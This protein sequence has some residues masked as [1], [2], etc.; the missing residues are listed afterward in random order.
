MNGNRSAIGFQRKTSESGMILTA[1][2]EERYASPR[3]MAIPLRLDENIKKRAIRTLPERK[4]FLRNLGDGLAAPLELV[5]ILT[6]AYLVTLLLPTELRYKMGVKP[7]TLSALPG[8]LLHPFLHFGARHLFFNAMALMIFGWLISLRSARTLMAVTAA[9]WLL[10]GALLWL[11]GRPGTVVGGA[12]GIVYGYLGFLLLRGIFD[13][14][15]VSM[16]LSLVTLYFFH[17]ALAGLLPT[18]T[19]VSWEGHLCGFAAGV[20]CAYLTKS[21]PRRGAGIRG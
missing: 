4:S 2:S 11:M 13:K 8:I 6:A 20:F 1:V 14:R 15:F 19:Q 5:A 21:S 3:N 7:R 16:G 18:D 10:G 17:G 12:S 9:S